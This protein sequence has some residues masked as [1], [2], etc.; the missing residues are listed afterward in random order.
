MY[1]PLNGIKLIVFLITL[2]QLVNVLLV[3]ST[4]EILWYSLSLV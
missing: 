1:H 2:L 4:W 3:V